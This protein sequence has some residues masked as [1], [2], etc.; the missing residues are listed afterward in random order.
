MRKPYNKFRVSPKSE[1]TYKDIVF[2]SK[3]EMN[4]FK[5]LEIMQERGEISKLE[6]QITYQFKYNGQLI[7]EYCADFKYVTLVPIVWQRTKRIKHTWGIGDTVI[8][9]SKGK[10][11]PLYVLKCKMMKIFHGITIYETYAEPK[12]T[13]GRKKKDATT[14]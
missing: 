2:D 10:R 4:R 14:N 11:L 13:T 5:Q 3:L 8:E 7:C 1:R 6:R 9:D 12:K